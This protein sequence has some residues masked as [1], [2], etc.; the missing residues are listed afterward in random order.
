MK[1]LKSLSKNYQY[2][3]NYKLINKY[4]KFKNFR[5]IGMGGSIL[6]AEAIYHFLNHKIKKNFSFINNLQNKLEF[7][8]ITKVLLI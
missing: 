6:G 2:N 1:V 8:G 7:K 4:K 5:I 3:F